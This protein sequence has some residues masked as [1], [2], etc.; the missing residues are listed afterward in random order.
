MA[1]TQNLF[2]SLG[3]NP[4]LP[5]INL[6]VEYPAE[7][8]VYW[9]IEY[10]P[11]TVRAL[12]ACTC[13]ARL[14]IIYEMYVFFQVAKAPKVTW[15]S[16]LSNRKWT[17]LLI[18]HELSMPQV[19]FDHWIV[20]VLFLLITS[21]LFLGISIILLFLIFPLVPTSLPISWRMVRPCRLLSHLR[22]LLMAVRPLLFSPLPSSSL[23]RCRF[24]S[25][26]CRSSLLY[27]SPLLAKWRGRFLELEAARRATQ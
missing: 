2:G 26:F 9:G 14:V 4:F 12:F 21:N 16:F 18:G 17:L 7:Q 15:D 3:I 1:H 19:K 13:C 5:R 25:H 10:G 8:L 6:L 23:N 11:K 27:L 22:L 24:M 20:Y